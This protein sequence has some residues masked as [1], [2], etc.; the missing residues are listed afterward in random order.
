MHW[1]DGRACSGCG[2]PLMAETHHFEG[3]GKKWTYLAPL[4][5]NVKANVG[6]C[7]PACV[8]EWTIANRVRSPPT[9]D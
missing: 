1:V 5:H 2:K 8:M 4:Y 9:V 7:G 6:F 3:N